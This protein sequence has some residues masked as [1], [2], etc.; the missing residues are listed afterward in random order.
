MSDRIDVGTFAITQN[1]VWPANNGLVVIIRA[2]DPGTPPEPLRYCIERVDGE[3]WFC[4]HSLDG[5]FT[6]RFNAVRY[7][8]A[9]RKF[10]RPIDEYTNDS[11][12]LEAIRSAIEQRKVAVAAAWAAEA[13]E[14]AREA[15]SPVPE[16]VEVLP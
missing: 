2:I 3:K 6:I 16:S 8:W 1:S 4:S 12:E 15:D 9:E 7:P 13:V 5:K 11:E 14:K 10:L